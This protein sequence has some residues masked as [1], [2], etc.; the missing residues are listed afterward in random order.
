[1]A[2][3]AN[4][5]LNPGANKYATTGGWA[6]GRLMTIAF[7]LALASVILRDERTILG[8]TLSSRVLVAAGT[9][10]YGIYLWHFFFINML[11]HSQLWRLPATNLI[12]ITALTVGASLASWI[13]SSN[14]YFAL[15]IEAGLCL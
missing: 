2:V 6:L 9:I 11:H 3:L 8:R 12:L 14:R 1:M 7:G 13:V 10:S 15:E 5:L 4:A